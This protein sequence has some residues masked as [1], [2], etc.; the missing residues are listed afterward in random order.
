MGEQMNKFTNIQN[1]ISANGSFGV[2]SIGR[3]IVNDESGDIPHKNEYNDYHLIVLAKGALILS[4]KN[5]MRYEMKEY[6]VAIIRPDVE[7]VTLK[8]GVREDYWM[9]F[10]GVDEIMKQLNLDQSNEMIFH[11]KQ[12]TVSRLIG[13]FNELITEI[14]L[15]QFGYEIFSREKLLQLLLVISRSAHND[16]MI[17]GNNIDKIK[18]AL[19]EMNNNYQKTKPV[20]YYAELCN[21]SQSSFMHTFSRL[22]KTTPIKFINSLKLAN[23]KS[24]LLDS[25][26]T[27]S[28][29]ADMLGFSSPLY[30]S[31][32]FFKEFRIRPTD[33]RKTN[34]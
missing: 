29:I 12:N 6:D 15:Q 9:N 31:D 24:L 25:T 30:F 11:F 7:T 18:P 28:E 5:G 3:C 8:R 10:Y 17:S 22:M 32:L 2:R 21:M 20:K 27:I 13:I 4:N 19:I 16:K 33:Y 1:K 26:L 34:R 23:A 14:Q